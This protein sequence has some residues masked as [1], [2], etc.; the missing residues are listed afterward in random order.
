M[1][2]FI[3]SGLFLLTVL[4]ILLGLVAG[5]VALVSLIVESIARGVAA[6]A[7]AMSRRCGTAAVLPQLRTELSGLFSATTPAGGTH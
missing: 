2:A 5:S 6:G 1:R 4:E 3:I 7:H